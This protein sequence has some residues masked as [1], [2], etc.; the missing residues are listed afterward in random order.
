M[1]LPDLAE[2]GDFLQKLKRLSLDRFL[3]FLQEKPSNQITQTFKTA[4][5]YSNQDKIKFKLPCFA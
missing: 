5:F 3:T 1:I 4:N 2:Y